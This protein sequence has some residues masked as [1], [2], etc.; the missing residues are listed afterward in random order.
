M[1]QKKKPCSENQ[2]THFMFNNFIP[3][4]RTVYDI[5]WKNIVEPGRPHLTKWR[6]SIA[7]WILKATDT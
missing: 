1:F 3:E 5:T 4:N 6:M 2:N 7:C